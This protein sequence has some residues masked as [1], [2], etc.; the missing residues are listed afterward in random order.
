M[1][2]KTIANRIKNFDMYGKMPNGLSEGTMSGALS[3]LIC[4]TYLI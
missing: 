3:K 2:G 1:F 4:K